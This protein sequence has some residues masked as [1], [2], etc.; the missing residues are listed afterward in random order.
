VQVWLEQD[1]LFLDVV[2]SVFISGLELVRRLIQQVV[3]DVVLFL[4]G[5]RLGLKKEDHIFRNC[6]TICQLYKPVKNG[7]N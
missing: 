2:Q 1:G 7:L 6:T 3:V 5:K 4:R